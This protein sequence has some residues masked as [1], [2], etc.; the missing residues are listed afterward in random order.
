MPENEPRHV[1][2]YGTLRRSAR[3]DINRL[4]PK[5]RYLGMGEVRGQLY[6]IDWYPALMLGGET[7]VTV[8]GEVYEIVAELEVLLDEI[9]QI[10]PGGDS[11]YFK[12]NLMIEVDGQLLECLVYEVNPKKVRGLKPLGYGDWTLFHPT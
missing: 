2:V 12:R 1:F 4:L 8:L 10:V 9:E 6:L 3:N 11:E 5:P 7:P